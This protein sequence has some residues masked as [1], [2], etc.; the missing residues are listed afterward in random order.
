VTSRSNAPA[1]AGILINVTP[2]ARHILHQFAG[3]MRAKA[4]PQARWPR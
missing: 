3:A 1:K 2:C 4:G